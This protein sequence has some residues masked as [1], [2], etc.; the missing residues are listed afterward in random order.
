MKEG[1]W[2]KM[3]RR[4]CYSIHECCVCKEKILYRQEYYDGGHG[5]RM[6]VKCFPLYVQAQ[7]KGERYGKK[8]DG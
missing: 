7:M 5:H 6:H 4:T 8:H 1:H 2:K 3:P